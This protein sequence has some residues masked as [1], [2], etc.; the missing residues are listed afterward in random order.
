MQDGFLIST[1]NSE[2]LMNQVA[3]LEDISG[4]ISDLSLDIKSSQ[5]AQQRRDILTWLSDHHYEAQYQRAYQLHCPD[6]SN[7]ILNDRAFIDWSSARS[8]LLWMHG[9]VGT[10]KTVAT[11]YLINHLI[12]KQ[13]GDSLLGYFYYDASTIESL[14]PETFFGAITK[15]FCSTLP[16]IPEKIVDSYERASDAFGNPKQP[17]LDQL[18]SFLHSL[19]DSHDSATIVVDG[20]DESPN[21]GA[22]CDFLTSTVSAGIQPLRVFVSSRPE[23]DL[24]RRFNGFTEMRIRE[25]AIEEDITKYIEMRIDTN[26]R[27][28]RM[29]EHMKKYVKAMLRDDS[30]GM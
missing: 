23:L 2:A 21:Y 7:W 15:Q 19:L 24:R 18:K 11:S 20:L 1:S 10:G 12:A 13:S 3:T 17:T 4:S 29:S 9:K 22:V 6:T 16:Q 8:S 27:L 28:G 25:V 30:N 14:T 5:L 26:P